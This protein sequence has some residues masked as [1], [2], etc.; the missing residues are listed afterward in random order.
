MPHTPSAAKQ[1]RQSAKR[2]LRNRSM[3]SAIK[4]A[5][6]KNQVAAASKDAGKSQDALRHAISLLD[7]AASKGILHRNTVARR[8]SALMRAGRTQAAQKA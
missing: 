5:L 8:K 3:K 7:R 4:T 2:R 1:I 6:L